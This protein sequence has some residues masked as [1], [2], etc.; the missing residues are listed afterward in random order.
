METRAIEQLADALKKGELPDAQAWDIGAAVWSI[1]DSLPRGGAGV[2]DVRRAVKALNGQ[3]QYDHTRMLAQA[4]N[5]VCGF[6]AT[7]T[8]HQA[9]A[10]INL[11]ALV[12]AERLLR[13]GLVRIQVPE[14]GAQAASEV[15]EYQ[16]LLGRIYK[17]RF[18]ATGDKDSLVKATDQ[19]FAQY[20]ANPD[21]PYW[22]GINAAA[23]LA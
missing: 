15:L 13:D 4:W 5:D 20:D 22:H 17:Q 19:Y 18:V 23:L 10:L 12:A 7:I 9:Q 3:R 6:D 2:A 8:K 11:S 1:V 16:G 21:K 14:A